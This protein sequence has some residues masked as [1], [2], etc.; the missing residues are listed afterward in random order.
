MIGTS[1]DTK[2]CLPVGTSCSTSVSNTLQTT[3]CTRDYKNSVCT[4]GVCYYTI[5]SAVCT[6]DFTTCTSTV[7]QLQWSCANCVTIN[8]CAKCISGFKNGQANTA[9]VCLGSTCNNIVTVNA[10]VSSCANGVD[11]LGFKCGCCA[12]TNQNVTACSSNNDALSSQ[13]FI[14]WVL[15]TSNNNSST[16][17]NTSKTN[18]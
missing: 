9:E 16:T 13:E 2:Y 1:L 6:K 10:S 4:T 5:N 18:F 15:G 11:A 14:N 17:N 12:T 7:D 3:A 8:G